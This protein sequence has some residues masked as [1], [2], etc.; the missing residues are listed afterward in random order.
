MM[1]GEECD[2]CV[3]IGEGDFFCLLKEEIVMSDFA[4]TDKF[5]C[6]G[7][8]KKEVRDNAKKKRGRPRKYTED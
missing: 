4:P 3:Y 7:F 6:C 8:Q 2:N 1:C 5:A